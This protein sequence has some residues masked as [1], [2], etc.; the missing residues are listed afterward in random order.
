MAGAARTG[1]PTPESCE[2]ARRVA[3]GLAGAWLVAEEPNRDS[4]AACAAQGGEEPL[5]RARLAELAVDGLLDQLVSRS[6]ALFV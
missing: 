3:R 5:W 6:G 2:P 1:L 4:D